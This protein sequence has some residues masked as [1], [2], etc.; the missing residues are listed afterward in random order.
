MLNRDQRKVFEKEMYG[1]E[2]DAAIRPRK[3]D[4]KVVPKGRD[5][6]VRYGTSLRKKNVVEE[7]KRRKE[8]HESHQFS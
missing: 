2:E 3:V 6:H 5:Y 8:Y 4:L 1:D 7:I